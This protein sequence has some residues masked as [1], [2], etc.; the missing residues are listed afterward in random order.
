MSLETKEDVI[1][2]PKHYEVVPNLKAKEIVKLVLNSELCDG[3]T[4]Y[5]KGCLFSVLKYR[6]R[7]GKKD[8]NNPLQDLAKSDEFVA[9][10]WD[11]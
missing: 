7:A 3:M 1:K 5:Q 6:L 10:G 8:G 9:M 2:A 4:G 11:E